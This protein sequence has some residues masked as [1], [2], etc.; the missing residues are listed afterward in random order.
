ME[1]IIFSVLFF[2]MPGV[3]F[4]LLYKLAG[5]FLGRPVPVCL[6]K[7][8]KAP[9]GP[10]EALIQIQSGKNTIERGAAI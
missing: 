6:R 7:C 4:K 5:T 2:M 1:R 3:P 8:L 10:Q 9:K